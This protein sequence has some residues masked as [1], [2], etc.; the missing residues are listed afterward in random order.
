M[1]D[2][3]LKCLQYYSKKANTVYDSNHMTFWKRK[4]LCKTVGRAVV[5]RIWGGGR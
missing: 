2:D 4:K 5:S 3:N 1:K